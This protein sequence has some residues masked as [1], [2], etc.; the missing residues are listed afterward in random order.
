MEVT[1]ETI[2]NC[3]KKCGIGRCELDIKISLTYLLTIRL[4]MIVKLKLTF[5]VKDIAWRQ[6]YH[7]AAIRLGK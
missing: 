5:E 4:I 1:A 6:L 2:E 3:F 7:Q